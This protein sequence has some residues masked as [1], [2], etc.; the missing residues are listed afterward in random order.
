MLVK[1]CARVSWISTAS[2]IRSAA[3]PISGESRATSARLFSSSSMS[4]AHS[5]LCSITRTIHNP[6]RCW[7]AAPTQECG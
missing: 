7:Q 6:S 3:T 1:P 4:R 5:S 2:R